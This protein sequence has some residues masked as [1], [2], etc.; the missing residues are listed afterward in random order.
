MK[1]RNA[2]GRL[3]VMQT[4]REATTGTA[5]QEGERAM[6]YREAT[7]QS[8]VV[9]ADA[10][11][12]PRNVPREMMRPCPERPQ[13]DRHMVEGRSQIHNDSPSCATAGRDRH[14]RQ[15]PPEAGLTAPHIMSPASPLNRDIIRREIDRAV[16]ETRAEVRLCMRMRKDRSRLEK[17]LGALLEITT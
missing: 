10:G 5:A 3:S 8:T 14:T 2:R 16:R 4:R 12:E 9:T 17:V 7:A 1:I 6:M 11:N 15:F 13:S